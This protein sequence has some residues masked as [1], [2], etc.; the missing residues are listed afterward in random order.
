MARWL[1]SME[2]SVN[3][4]SSELRRRRGSRVLSSVTY[5]DAVINE[6]IDVMAFAPSGSSARC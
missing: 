2:V 1:D 3:G 5:F 6:S 4:K